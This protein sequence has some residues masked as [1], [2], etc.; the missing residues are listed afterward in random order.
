MLNRMLNRCAFYVCAFFSLMLLISGIFSKNHFFGIA[1][2]IVLLVLAIWINEPYRTAL[3]S[4]LGQ[5]PTSS[6]ET[7]V[8][9]ASLLT[10]FLVL[11]SYLGYVENKKMAGA[12]ASVAASTATNSPSPAAAM[13]E[14]SKPSAPPKK[15]CEQAKSPV[16]S[17]A[18]AEGVCLVMKRMLDR[19]PA[20]DELQA[21]FATSSTAVKKFNDAPTDVASQIISIVK[22]RGL[23]DDPNGVTKT[24][25]ILDKLASTSDTPVSPATVVQYLS[26]HKDVAKTIGEAELMNIQSVVAR[27]KVY[28]E[29]RDSMSGKL[30]KYESF[31]SRNT[32][33]F[34]FPYQG[35]TTAHL[36]LRNHPQYGKDVIF[37]ISKGQLLCHSF[38]NC[39]VSISI[40][41][42]PVFTVSGV[43]AEDG[44]SRTVFLNWSLVS[45][46]KNAKSIKI[47][48]PTY[49]N[50]RPVFDFDLAGIDVSRMN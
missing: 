46:L 30:T 20:E 25:M 6:K 17:G 38:S 39:S 18:D 47:Q 9:G 13:P 48:P 2:G 33:E 36:V 28:T 5:E 26:N 34:S 3:L 42:G 24:T 19:M 14:Q 50:G 7:T 45:K 22:L 12:S 31:E 4:Q 1:M 23:I 27:D 49:Q 44:S 29:E 37:E 10:M 32:V 11:G 35:G 41:G 8:V 21:V 16:L 40:D 15:T 43:G